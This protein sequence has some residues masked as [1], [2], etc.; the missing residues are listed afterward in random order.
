MLGMDLFRDC[1]TPCLDFDGNKV[2]GLLQTHYVY[3]LF[4]RV[5]AAD[6]KGKKLREH[7]REDPSNDS[8]PSTWPRV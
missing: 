3:Q 4:D 7:R 6:G 1:S 8:S 5:F 2:E